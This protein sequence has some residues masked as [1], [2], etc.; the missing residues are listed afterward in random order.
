[1]PLQAACRSRF[2]RQLSMEPYRALPSGT[3]FGARHALYE[4]NYS[5]SHELVRLFPLQ[6]AH[7]SGALGSPKVALRSIFEAVA[8]R[9]AVSC[10]TNGA[11]CC[12]R[13][14][15]CLTSTP[16]SGTTTPHGRL[17]LTVL[18]GLAEFERELIR[19]CASLHGLEVS[20]RLRVDRRNL[21]WPGAHA[22]GRGGRAHDRLSGAA[23]ARFD[24]EG[25]QA[26]A[27]EAHDGP[28]ASPAG[29]I[30][31]PADCSTHDAIQGGRR[32]R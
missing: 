18:G 22:I 23:L 4:M 8:G 27:R 12:W 24:P 3:E 13:G 28:P 5:G 25:S 19:A 21:A 7:A 26:A 30:K 20:D 10:I 16:S 6:Q 1:M 31:R 15:S 17:M 2:D 32:C 11:S 14:L 9:P 29:R